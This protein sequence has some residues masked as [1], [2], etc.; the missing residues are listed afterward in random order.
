MRRPPRLVAL[1]LLGLGLLGGALGGTWAAFSATTSSPAGSLAAKRVFPGDR[2]VTAFDLRDASGGSESNV[3][4]EPAYDDAR[5]V[6]TAAN[7]LSSYNAA[8]YVDLTL[9]G[10]RPSG[11][12]VTGPQFVIELA[13]QGGKD[14]GNACFWFEVRRASTD[15][16]LGSHGSGSSPVAC[17][18]G[19]TSSTTSTSIPSVTTTDF[20]NDLKI[21]AYLWETGAKK[22]DIDQAVVTGSTPY[23]SFTLYPTGLGDASGGGAPATTTWSLVAADSSQHD[24]ASNWA[25]SFSSTRYLKAAFEPFLPTGATVS[26]ATLTH[27]YRSRDSGATTCFYYEVYEGTTLLGAHGSSSSPYSC[28]SSN[29]TWVTDSVALSEVTGP[30]QANSLVIR[31]YGRNSAGKKSQTDRT[32]VTFTSHLD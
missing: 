17:S 23:A 27:A 9:A 19:A 25:T 1:A 20:A 10:A 14:S 7:L 31:L 4:W 6:R 13:S 22:V 24:S 21:R 29:S 5:M 16:V 15:E 26:A 11:L 32:V 18:S 12:S 30:V 28:N 3:S 8:R 2:V